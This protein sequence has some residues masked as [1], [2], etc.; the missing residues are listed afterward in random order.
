M[1]TSPATSS[2]HV[3]TVAPSETSKSKSSRSSSTIKAQRAAV[4]ALALRRRLEH[5]Q[6]LAENER[7]R[8][9]QLAERERQREIQLAERERQ[10]ELQL[11]ERERQR[12]SRLAARRQQV[13]E[14][15]LQAELAALDAEAASSRSSRSG[16][17]RI[18]GER[19][20][21][22][23]QSLGQPVCVGENTVIRGIPAV[24]REQLVVP[25]PGHQAS[26]PATGSTASPINRFF[27]QKQ[28]SNVTRPSE[29]AVLCV[30]KD[31]GNRGI[32][33]VG[34]EPLVVPPP[35]HQASLPATGSTASPINRFVLQKQLSN[36]T[37]A[38]EAAVLTRPLI[39]TELDQSS[40]LQAVADTAAAAKAL[41][42][43]H[44][45]KHKI[46]LFPFDGDALTWLHF[47][48]IFDLTKSNFSDIENI[49]RLQNAH[50]GAARD[51]V[52]SLLLATDDPTDII[53]A[54]EE[55]FARPETIL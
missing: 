28:L 16:S 55:N 12:E 43:S 38:S 45:H 33:A 53:R 49:S 27:H 20:E 13:E 54:L 52:A 22:W 29:A 10:R 11:A 2:Q 48:R 17:A 8:E 19:T 51:A 37:K 6:E 26:L 5:E 9:L 25:P 39:S 47:K 35:G 46:E 36:I 41:A 23:V 15:E 3:D 32:P 34:R 30:G 24:G 21:R 42:T 18:S 31:T 14:G 7:Q 40:L 4:E 50:R 44:R 1:P